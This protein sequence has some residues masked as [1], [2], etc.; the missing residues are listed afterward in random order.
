MGLL[1]G[2][3]GWDR[4]PLGNSTGALR[5]THPP[6]GPAFPQER[7]EATDLD[8]HQFPEV[9]TPPFIPKVQTADKESPAQGFNR[10]LE[11]IQAL[12]LLDSPQKQPIGKAEP[13]SPGGKAELTASLRK[14]LGEIQCDGAM[15][16]RQ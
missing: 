11:R 10:R 9:R 2:Q 1:D 5:P 13:A 16:Q 8:D 6:L 3:Q 15:V 12:T 14:D 7:N 4:R